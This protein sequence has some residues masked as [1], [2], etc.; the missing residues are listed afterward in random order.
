MSWQSLLKCRSLARG[1]YS[2]IAPSGPRTTLQT[3]PYCQNVQGLK[4]KETQQA[5]SGQHLFRNERKPSDFDKKV[6]MWTGRYKKQEDIPAYVSCEV[7]S[8][9][10]SKLRIRIC[11]AMIGGTILGCI[12]MVVS[13]K[14]AIKEDNTLLRRNLERKAKWKEEAEK[15]QAA[16]KDH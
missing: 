4:P 6:L 2:Y 5:N 16:L 12:I 15:E 10:R 14:R 3:R 1:V 8:A 9:A 7:I 11:Y 13:G